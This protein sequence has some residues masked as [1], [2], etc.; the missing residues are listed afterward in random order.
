MIQ[1][2]D[3]KQKN[4]QMHSIFITLN[5]NLVTLISNALRGMTKRYKSEIF[6]ILK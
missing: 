1:C 5:R 4:C 3:R 2:A 6:L